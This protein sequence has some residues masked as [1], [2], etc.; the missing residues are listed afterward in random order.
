MANYG[1]PDE[2]KEIS[3]RHIHGDISSIIKSQEVVNRNVL[4][5]NQNVINSYLG[6]TTYL[7]FIT[8]AVASVFYCFKLYGLTERVQ[9]IEENQRAVIQR[10]DT[11]AAEA[12]QKS[13]Y[14]VEKKESSE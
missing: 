12:W 14:P 10:L 7:L 13:Y 3:L 11:K 2:H 1:T 5:T 9:A 6:C 8:A 4:I